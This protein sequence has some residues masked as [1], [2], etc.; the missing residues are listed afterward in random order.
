[1]SCIKLVSSGWISSLI[2]MFSKPETT[3]VGESIANSMKVGLTEYG[4]PDGQ[5]QPLPLSGPD[6]VSVVLV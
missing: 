2:E 6:Y 5:L 3:K 1:M 4:P